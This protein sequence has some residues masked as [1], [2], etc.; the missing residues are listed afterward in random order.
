[1]V[2]KKWLKALYYRYYVAVA[3]N[4]TFN[5]NRSKIFDALNC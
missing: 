2:A 4:P 3:Q 5:L 1:M